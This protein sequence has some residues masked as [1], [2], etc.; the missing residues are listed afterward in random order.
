MS[1]DD[2]SVLQAAIN[3]WPN[4]QR[5]PV[6]ADLSD[7]A[8]RALAA[9][10]GLASRASRAGDIASLLRQVLLT[11][12]ACFGGSLGFTVPNSDP[13]PTI[14]IW[15]QHRCDAVRGGDARLLVT[16]TP[17]Y[18]GLPT[19]PSGLIDPVAI[20]E[21]MACYNQRPVKRPEMLDA[22]PFWQVATGWAKYQGV[23]QQQ[24]ARAVALSRQ[25]A[26][27]IVALPTGGGKTAIG[28][29]R[30]ML[31]RSGVSVVVVPTVILAVDM[32]RR[33][34]RYAAETGQRLS[35]I[36]RYA[37]TASLD[38]QTKQ[39]LRAAVRAGT[40]RVIYT[41]PEAFVSGLAGAVMACAA[42][43]LLSQVVIDEAHLVD[44][45]GQDFRPEFQ[46]M[47]GLVAAAYDQSP[48]GSQPLVLMLSA[49]LAQRHIEV[50][51]ST[52]ADGGPAGLIWGT[53]LRA[54]PTYFVIRCATE[55][56]QHEQV[57][58][59]A[60]CLPK[61][62]ILYTT[63]VDDAKAWRRR[64]LDN[65]LAR[66]GLVTGESSEEERRTVYE[67]WRG[68]AA[69]A[70]FDVAGSDF[71]VV[72]GTSAFG[73]GIDMP[74]VRT[75]LHA[76]VP[77][78]ID[79]Y[80]QEV[81]RAGRD[82][83]ASVA[84]LYYTPR[85]HRV[86]QDL[87][88]KVVI[89]SEK[90]WARWSALRNSAERLGS[91]SY[92][93]RRTVVPPH[94]AEGYGE[95]AK[96]N[97]RTLTLMAQVGMIRLRAPTLGERPAGIKDEQWREECETF[98][99]NVRDYM[100]FDILDGR[101]LSEKRWKA[102][103]ESARDRVANAQGLALTSLDTVLR[104][105]RCTGAVIA[106]HYRIVRAGGLLIPRPSCRGCPWCRAHPERRTGIDGLE[107]APALPDDVQFSDPLAKWRHRT[108]LVYVWWSSEQQYRDLLPEALHKLAQRGISVFSGVDA[109]MAQRLQ[110]AAA[111]RPVVILGDYRGWEGMHAYPGPIVHVQQTAA[112]PR[113]IADRIDFDQSTYLFAPASWPDPEKPGWQLRDT[114]D[115]SVGLAALI[116]EL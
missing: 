56:G 26:R 48:E 34:R 88:K 68:P 106:D 89:G 95:S 90:G 55:D 100:D 15:A 5:E 91:A 22:D 36:D 84:A 83:L 12:T 75:V 73:L 46:T 7:A 61:P 65:G 71:D 41:S 96:W 103:I 43:G 53:A 52:L 101:D 115:C 105:D 20:R 63:K 45:W 4:Q 86:A 39:D 8:K 82:R 19:D 58:D 67:R 1:A 33:T 102:T 57:L 3:N 80:Y 79:R 70:D 28:W 98:A 69:G 66:V 29:V 31:A 9:L 107:P 25:G 110:R 11:S 27:L 64:L 37:Y 77:E 10:S 47:A 2:L 108:T 24:S 18:P 85:D 92:R 112:M 21:V 59:A 50:L 76:C 94:L 72:V 93:V 17:W 13:W 40:Q 62:M 111:P 113:E 44:Q 54:E 38:E 109:E 114:A 60:R 42:A 23:S 97:L 99:A 49:T 116:E 81:G 87:N 6:T 51:E 74:N 32:E 104:G 16:A 78:T 30:P 14:S 35:P